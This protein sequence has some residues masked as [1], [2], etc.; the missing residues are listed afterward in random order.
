MIL[1]G[2]EITGLTDDSRKVKPGFMFVCIKGNR[3][4]GH[5]AAKQALEQGA[6]V[7]VCERDLGLEDKQIIVE[8]T[9]IAYGELCAEYF[10]N[11]HKK[12]KF[13]GIT[14][15]NGKTTETNIVKYCLTACN[16]KTGLIGT[17]QNEIGDKI[18]HTDNTT[19]FCY[20]LFE[21]LAKMAEENCE[22]VVMEVS[23]FGLEQKRI[24]PIHFDIA[25]FTNL[26]RD[27][28]DE[29]KTME[30]YYLAKK[31]LFEICDTAVINI[32]DEYGK[33]LYNEINCNKKTFSIK[34]KADYYSYDIK[35]HSNHS[36]FWYNYSLDNEIK[37]QFLQTKLIGMFN[38]SNITAC[39]SV[40]EYLGLDVFKD[41]EMYSGTKGRCEVIPTNRDFTVIRDYAHTPDAL[42]NILKTLKE[43]SKGKI[44]CLVGCGGNRDKTKRPLMGAVAS[45]YADILVITSDNPR[46]ENP[47]DIIDDI[48]KG[49]KSEKTF[50]RITDRL[51]AIKYA[52]DIAGKG[53][54]ILLAGKGHEDYQIFENNRHI[55]FD[56]REIVIDLT[57]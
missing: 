2:R 32:D 13:I 8:D 55:H 30:N 37:S 56:E 6:E 43:C 23:S 7:I 19:P 38:I 22:Y 27:H 15:T 31:Q 28:L 33:R 10:G 29:H 42:E 20:E 25:V 26:T 47:E 34:E 24:G 1:S 57:K 17:I 44:I 52:L 46:D 50:E 3:F 48:I 4:D 18:I 5:N 45:E 21:L 54:V 40:C 11:P 12:M 39:L 51:E 49:V 14:G 53:D 9:R 35:L 36:E 16:K 41:I